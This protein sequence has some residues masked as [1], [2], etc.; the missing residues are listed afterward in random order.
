M[1]SMV[2]ITDRGVRFSLGVL[3][4]GR[5]DK[6]IAIAI[7]AKSERSGFKSLCFAPWEARQIATWLLQACNLAEGRDAH[8]NVPAWERT[9]EE[10]IKETAHIEKT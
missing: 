5:D 9:T 7:D 2:K 10:G 4:D 6:L 1:S 3:E 8:D